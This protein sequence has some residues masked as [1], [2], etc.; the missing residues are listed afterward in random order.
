MRL[1]SQDGRMDIPYENN[2]V[3]VYAVHD[4]NKE[5]NYSVTGYK[6]VTPV[7]YDDSWTLGDYSTKEKTLQV[8][9]M[10][11]QQYMRHL[12]TV[13]SDAKSESTY[14]KFPADEDVKE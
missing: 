9:K 4:H 7:G 11:Q 13:L 5:R 14:F 3:Y 6:I 1:I 12:T 2:I 8:M 10:L